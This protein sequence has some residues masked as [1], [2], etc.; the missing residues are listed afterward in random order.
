VGIDVTLARVEQRGTSPRRRSTETLA[1]V[2]DDGDTLAR[3]LPTSGLPILSR[4]RVTPDTEL[5]FEGD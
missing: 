2:R 1:V 3:L 4:C 5:R